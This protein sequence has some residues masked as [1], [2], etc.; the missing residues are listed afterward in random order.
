MGLLAAS[1]LTAACLDEGAVKGDEM[2]S[3]RPELAVIF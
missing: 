2:P 3:A 1:W